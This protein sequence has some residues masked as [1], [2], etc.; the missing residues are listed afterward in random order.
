SFIE[1]S[2]KSYHAGLEQ[3]DFMHAWEDSRKQINGWVE[4]RTEGKIRNLLAQGIVNS[5]TRLVLVNAIYFKGS[6]EKQF[7]KERT[8]EMPFQVNK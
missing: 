7:N 3:T 8:T 4:E 2:E 5:L 6:W 1:A